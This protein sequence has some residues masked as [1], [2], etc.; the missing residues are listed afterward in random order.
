MRTDIWR[1]T[2]LDEDRINNVIRGERSRNAV[3]K[4]RNLTRH[5]GGK[6]GK[7]LTLGNG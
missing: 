2:S 3:D 4:E 1:P 7:V 5:V 6:V